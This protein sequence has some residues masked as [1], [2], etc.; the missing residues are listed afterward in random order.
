M[1]R[2]EMERRQHAIDTDDDRWE[3]EKWMLPVKLVNGPKRPC[4]YN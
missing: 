1:A 3:S 2:N 4:K